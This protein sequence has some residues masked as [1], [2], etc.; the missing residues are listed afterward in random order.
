MWI[1]LD[2][3]RVQHPSH[4]QPIEALHVADGFGQD[5]SR[6]HGGHLSAHLRQVAKVTE[7]C[8]H[9]ESKLSQGGR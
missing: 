3:C 4:L 1:L 5:L 8:L 7:P 9:E 2:G 6:L